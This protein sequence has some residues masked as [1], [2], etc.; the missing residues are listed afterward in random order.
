[1]I[2]EIDFRANKYA[3]VAAVVIHAQ[4]TMTGS[5]RDFLFK[6][7]IKKQ[8]P[9]LLRRY[10]VG[11]GDVNSTSG[12]GNN[13]RMDFQTVAIF[14]DGTVAVSFVDSTTGSNSPTTGARRTSPA[15]AVE[16]SSRGF[17]PVEPPEP[18]P[19]GVA[20]GP[21]SS[22][23]IVPAPGAGERVGGVT[24]AYLEFEVPLGADV[25]RMSAHAA[26]LT[27]A[28]VDLYLQRQLA[29]GT[30]S[31]DVVS[32]TSGSLTEESLDSARLLAGS[33]YRVEAHLWAG[34]P[35][36]QIAMTATF[37]NSAGVPG[38]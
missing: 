19:V 21:I 20:P 9:Q 12:L 5:D 22:S 34:A 8:A 23:V 33:R 1:V 26:P 6:L 29:D 38:T 17:E 27:P 3:G 28:D 31:G 14:R 13:V 16:R 37:Y 30:W 36:T 7:G 35:A 32:G 2:E 18:Q 15:I 25:A 11:L 24:S 10:E 4:D